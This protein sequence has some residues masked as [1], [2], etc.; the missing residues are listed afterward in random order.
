[1]TTR[2]ARP[3]PNGGVDSAFQGSDVRGQGSEVVILRAVCEAN[4]VAK[5]SPLYERG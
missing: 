3:P 5:S 4:E 2:F 1:M